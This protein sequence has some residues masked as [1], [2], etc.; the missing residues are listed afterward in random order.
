MYTAGSGT[1]YYTALDML[2]LI[3]NK[4]ISPDT[5]EES[6]GTPSLD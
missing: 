2:E 5:K 6:G 1:T 4:S 3:D